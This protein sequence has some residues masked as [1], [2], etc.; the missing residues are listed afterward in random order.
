MK[1]K[2]MSRFPIP[3]PLFDTL[4]Y[5]K[6]SKPKVSISLRFAERELDCAYEFLMQYDGNQAT[7]N[8]YRREVE[9]L[10]HWT[11]LI[12][13][14]S[15]F[16][17]HKDDIEKYVKF[18]MKP[19]KSW[20]ALKKVYRFLTIQGER[21]ANPKWRPFVVTLSKADVN[22]GV[23]PTK[24]MYSL[25]QK[26]IREI[27]VILGSFYNHLITEGLTEI[28]PVTSIRQ[29]SKF[30]RKTQTSATVFR[31]SEVQ[32]KAVINAAKKMADTPPHHHERTLF[33]ISALYLMYL[34]ISE[35][36]ASERW[37]PQMNHFYQDSYGN[38]WFKTV[39]K[40]NK[41]RSITVSDG[42][43][44]TLKRWR[45]H[46][47]LSP[48]LPTADDHTPLLPKIKGKGNM[49]ATRVI[50]RIVQECFDRAVES[51]IQSGEPQEAESLQNATVHWLRHTG[52]SDDINKRDRPI[53]HVRDD[54]GHAS[55]ATTDRYNDI[56]LRERHSS[57]KTKD[58]E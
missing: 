29:K 21:I 27:F 37:S 45:K 42:M 13:E 34:R 24:D 46:L 50:R 17:L 19:P 6:L 12:A 1:I 9:R 39:G 25:S 53:A 5:C 47:E 20:I 18:C 35:L 38:W 44:A 32:W 36:V 23:Q 3:V 58:I 31:L 48:A 22:K 28:N 41:E 16:D 57:A 26:A 49:T 14:K 10:L 11:W 15:I 7:F 4:E 40:G 51:L 54:A 8:S 56:T 33:I 43:L 55:I 52:I 30:I 2:K